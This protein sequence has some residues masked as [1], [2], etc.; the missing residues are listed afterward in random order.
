MGLF[1]LKNEGDIIGGCCDVA[2][3]QELESNG[4]WE[5]TVKPAL[6][7]PFIKRNLS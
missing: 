2:Q 3:R 7:G 4:Q 1:L 6:N 5:Y